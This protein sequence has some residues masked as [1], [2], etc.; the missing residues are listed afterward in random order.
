M[1][2]LKRIGLAI[3]AVLIARALAWFLFPRI[4][5]EALYRAGVSLWTLPDVG[6]QRGLL[7]YLCGTGSP[8]LAEVRHAVPLGR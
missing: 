4:I 3:A 8:L 1:K 7:V 5:S 6:E 2:W